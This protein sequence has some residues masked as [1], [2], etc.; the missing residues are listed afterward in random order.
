MGKK[1]PTITWQDNAGQPITTQGRYTIENEGRVLVINNLVEAD[2][3]PYTCIGTNKLNTAEGTMTLNV[4]C[5]L[6]LLQR[7]SVQVPL[8]V[9]CFLSQQ[10]RELIGTH[11]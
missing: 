3:K 2:E 8:P 4:T 1:V 7:V 6:D 9:F 5:M 11:N 10:T